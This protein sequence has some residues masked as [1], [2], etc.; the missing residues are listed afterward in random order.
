[1]SEQIGLVSH[2]SQPVCP[3]STGERERGEGRRGE[4]ERNNKIQDRKEEKRK[5]EKG[6]SGIEM[7][8]K[9]RKQDRK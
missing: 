5:I 7:L 3:H 4:G 8:V 9:G 1:M 6:K 2:L